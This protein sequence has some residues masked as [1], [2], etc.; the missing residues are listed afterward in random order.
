[1][2]LLYPVDYCV[3]I[4]ICLCVCRIALCRDAPIVNIPDQGQ[5]MGFF[6]KM[7]R[8]QTIVGYLGIP[9][10]QPPIDDRRF[11]PPFVDTLPSWQGVRSGANVP[12]QC[13]SDVRKPL[14][15][16]DEIFFKILGIDP[17]TS[18]ASQF[19][20]DCLYLNI[21]VPDGKHINSI[22]SY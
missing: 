14:K 1:M 5:I 21:F 10:A 13:W 11:A 22:S 3:A 4:L 6:I 2:H 20:E 16:H 19:S 17:K 8:T 7:F 15:N 18:N 9:Y 12:M